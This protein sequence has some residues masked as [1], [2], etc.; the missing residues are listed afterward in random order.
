MIKIATVIVFIGIGL[1]MV[2]GIWNGEAVGFRNLTDNPFPAGFLATLGVFMAA[3]FSFQGTELIGV[4]AGESENPRENIPRAI[5]SIFWR[6]DFR[7][8]HRL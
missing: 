4:T 3:G 1:L 8:L 5:R 6:R 2:I 7:S